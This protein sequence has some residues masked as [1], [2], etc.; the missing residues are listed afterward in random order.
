LHEAILGHIAAKPHTT[1]AE[2]R[3]WLAAEHEISASDAL[4]CK[5]CRT[6]A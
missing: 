1:L 3:A 6:S 5:S 2:L 4:M